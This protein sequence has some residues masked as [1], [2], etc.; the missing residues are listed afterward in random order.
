MKYSRFIMLLVV[1][2]L[3]AMAG[4]G[5]DTGNGLNLNGSLTIS[6]ESADKGSYMEVT[7]TTTYTNPQKSDL[8]GFPIHFTTSAG[9]FT[10]NTNN[11]GAIKLTFP[12]PKTTTQQFFSF[13]ASSGDLIASTS[14]TIPAATVTPLTFST[15]PLPFSN[16]STASGR[17][18]KGQQI[19]VT[20]TNGIAPYTAMVSPSPNPDIS[21]NITPTTGNI[22]TVTKASS[23]SGSASVV[24]TDSSTPQM[25][26]TLTVN[27]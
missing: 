9:T 14:V 21:A 4:C 11:S 18:G 7:F 25:I 27:Y 10:M 19:I 22:V 24:V 2:V 23:A 1:V 17:N 6:S 8:L 26:G 13:A 15:N 20:I 5:E 16:T 12:V 3:L